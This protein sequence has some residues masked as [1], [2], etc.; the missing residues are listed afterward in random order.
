MKCLHVQVSLGNLD[1][2]VRFY[3]QLF[4]TLAARRPQVFIRVCK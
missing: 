3:S 2:S 1:A 4:A